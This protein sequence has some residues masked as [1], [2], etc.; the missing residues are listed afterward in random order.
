MNVNQI[1]ALT[2]HQIVSPEVLCCAAV[3]A[4]T[5][6]YFES[7]YLALIYTLKHAGI[8]GKLDVTPSVQIRWQDCC[9]WTTYP[10]GVFVCT[11]AGWHL[12]KPTQ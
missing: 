10:L 1:D 7:K 5:I 8:S 3:V 11:M 9:V 12:E 2:C 6:T 4:I